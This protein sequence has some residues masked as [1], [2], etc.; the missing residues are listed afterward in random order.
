MSRKDSIYGIICQQFLIKNTSVSILN[1]WKL[2]KKEKS[3][4]IPLFNIDW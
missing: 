3:I 1:K 2:S 4:I